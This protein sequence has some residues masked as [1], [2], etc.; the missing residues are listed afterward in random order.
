MAPEDDLEYFTRR[1]LQHA[2]AAEQSDEPAI[3]HAHRK[4]ADLHRR[5]ARGALEAKTER[6]KLQLKHSD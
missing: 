6:P 5:K 1:H 4:L 2:E 3:K